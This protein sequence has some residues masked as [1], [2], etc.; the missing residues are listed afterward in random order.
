[1][2]HTLTP[3]F[4][5]SAFVPGSENHPQI[6]YHV[7]VYRTADNTLVY[8]TGFIYDQLGHK[9]LYAPNSFYW[10]DPVTGEMRMARPLEYNTA[11]YLDVRFV[12]TSG[13]WGYWATSSLEPRADFFTATAT[14][15]LVAVRS[16]TIPVDSQV[17]L[18]IELTAASGF[19][20]GDYS[21]NLHFDAS[22][23]ALMS[24]DTMDTLSDSWEITHSTTNGIISIQGVKDRGQHIQSSGVLMRVKFDTLGFNKARSLCTTSNLS[25]GFTGYYTAPGYV[26]WYKPPSSGSG[27]TQATAVPHKIWTNLK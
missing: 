4:S 14:S 9:H 2:I 17:T 21:F 16:A 5:W 20:I 1:M 8:N 27:G 15:A 26:T 13:V 24:I 23:M 10:L 3:S 25:G 7:R 12:D 19:L 6:G 11:Y 18:D 22:E